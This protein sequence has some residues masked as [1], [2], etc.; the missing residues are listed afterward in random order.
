[1]EAWAREIGLPGDDVN[2]FVLGTIRDV[3]GVFDY[4]RETDRDVSPP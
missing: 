3:R 4:A 1:M 2:V